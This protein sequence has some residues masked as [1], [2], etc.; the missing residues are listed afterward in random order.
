VTEGKDAGVFVPVLRYRRNAHGYATARNAR[1]VTT[2]RACRRAA[3][4]PSCTSTRPRRPI[5]LPCS[6]TVL[7]IDLPFGSSPSTLPR[8]TSPAPRAPRGFAPRHRPRRAAPLYPRSFPYRWTDQGLRQ[9]EPGGILRESDPFALSC[10]G[11]RRD[12]GPGRG[13]RPNAFR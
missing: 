11:P 6:G 2:C 3:T 5:L 10:P 7:A 9:G 12:S 13:R 8:E 1:A 4:T